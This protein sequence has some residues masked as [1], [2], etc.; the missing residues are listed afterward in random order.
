MVG[1]SILSRD[2]LS[3][4]DLRLYPLA[5]FNPAIPSRLVDGGVSGGNYPD[6]LAEIPQASGARFFIRL[7]GSALTERQKFRSGQVVM[8]ETIL[9]ESCHI[10]F[11]NVSIGFRNGLPFM[12]KEE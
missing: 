9:P 4:P 8:T 11:R 3:N 10:W 7:S 5:C 12:T 6:Y 1:D 2:A